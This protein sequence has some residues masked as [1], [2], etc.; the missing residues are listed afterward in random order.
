MRVQTTA[1][2]FH[3]TRCSS[4]Y[5]RPEQLVECLRRHEDADARLDGWTCEQGPDR[6]AQV[7]RP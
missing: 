6:Q 1:L 3:C 5:P 2:P 7:E 4:T